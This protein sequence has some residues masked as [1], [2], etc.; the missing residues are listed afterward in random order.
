[1]LSNLYDSA[2]IKTDG[3]I[4]YQMKDI[5]DL[6]YRIN[7][8]SLSMSQARKVIKERW[9]LKQEENSLSYQKILEDG[10]SVPAKGRY[11]TF[12]EKLFKEL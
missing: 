11:F 7:H 5:C 3:V 1:M 4:Q 10:F 2:E 12:N 6:Y 9:G 8:K